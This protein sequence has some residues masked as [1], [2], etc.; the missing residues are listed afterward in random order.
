MIPLNSQLNLKFPTVLTN[1][2][3]PIIGS[4]PQSVSGVLRLTLE[5]NNKIRVRR[6]PNLKSKVTARSALNLLSAT[7]KSVGVP[8]FI[9][10][11]KL[12]DPGSGFHLG[13]SLPI[14]GDLVDEKARLRTFPQI[15]I[16]DTSILPV[17]PAGAHTF[18]TM[19]LIRTILKQES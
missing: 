10:A 2:I 14:S 12:A 6:I 18:L 5:D 3:L 17:I 16:L 1:R 15:Q 19:A 8:N 13:A 9:P 7:L 4:L 11:L